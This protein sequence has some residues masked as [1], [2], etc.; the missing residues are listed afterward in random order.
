MGDVTLFPT[1][2]K[3]VQ[4]EQQ[5]KVQETLWASDEVVTEWVESADPGDVACRE[6]A[7]HSYPRLKRGERASFVGRTKDGYYIRRVLCPSCEKVGLIELYLLITKKGTKNIVQECRLVYSRPDYRDPSY[8]AKPGVGRMR[9]RKI[10]EAVATTGLRGVDL[11]KLD[12][13]IAESEARSIQAVVTD[14]G[15]AHAG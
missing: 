13:E 15:E 14:D 2:P 5:E 10:R 7:R 3:S 12:A 11:R 6:Q 8:L 9:M 4:G 1:E